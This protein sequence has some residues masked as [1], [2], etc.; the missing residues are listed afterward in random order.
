M[1]D[2]VFTKI[3]KGEIPCHRVYEDER[4]IAFM[5]INPTLPYH[6][7]IASKTQIDHVYDLADEDYQALF[8]AAKK[9]ANKMRQ[10]LSPRRVA[11]LV[12]G[13]DIPH[14]HLNI[15]PTDSAEQII[16]AQYEQINSAQHPEPDHSK[17][18]E[19]AER[20]KI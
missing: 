18:A 20:L 5:D 8:A 4:T 11:T 3:I 2:S 1:S 19:M 15:L 13:F 7:V 16:K 12:M 17:L 10:T 6:V 14:A 9:V